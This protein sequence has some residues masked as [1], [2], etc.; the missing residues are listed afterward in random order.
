M[1]YLCLFLFLFVIGCQQQAPPA[2]VEPVRP[3]IINRP[4]VVIQ[5][6]IV[7]ERPGVIIQP[8]PIIINPHPGII[9]QPSPHHAG[10]YRVGPQYHHQR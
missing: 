4:P 1:R 2:V 3:I 7:I 9:I 8:R 10:P 5:R 6:P